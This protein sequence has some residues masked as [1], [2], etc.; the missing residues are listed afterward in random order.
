MSGWQ[1]SE[2]V[3]LS[4]TSETEEPD[5]EQGS[6]WLSSLVGVR[7]ALMRGDYRGLHLGWLAEAA[8]ARLDDDF[9]EPP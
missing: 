6:G 3:V 2:H 8:A 7:A 5:W 9:R 1:T 4:W